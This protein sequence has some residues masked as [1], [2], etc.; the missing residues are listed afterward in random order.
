MN[1]VMSE[2]TT[3]PRVRRADRKLQTFR[4]I[5]GE[6]LRLFLEK[7][8]DATTVEEVAAA[9][10]VSHMTVYRHFPNK[11]ALVLSDEWDPLLPGAI[12]NRPPHEGPL[13][14]LE[15]AFLDVLDSVSDDDIESVKTRMSLTLSHPTILSASLFLTLETIQVV[16]SALRERSVED[17][18]TLEVIASTAVTVGSMAA[19]DWVRQ[20]HQPSLQ[21][22]VRE[23]FATLRRVVSESTGPGAPAGGV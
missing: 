10:G 17:D 20:G 22:L 12:R 3:R 9:A 15:G 7:G 6:A 2:S 14:A 11:E 5:Q 16:V 21:Q 18:A 4:R 8:F 1:E 13:D 19:F 23:R